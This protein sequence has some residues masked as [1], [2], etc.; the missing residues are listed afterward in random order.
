MKQIEFKNLDQ[1]PVL[2]LMSILNEPS[3]RLHL[4]E[5][6]QFD[7]T[8][9]K[10]WINE[11]LKI[12]SLI[13]CRIRA[14]YVGG[15]C[16]GWCGIQPDDRGYEIAIVISKIAWGKGGS[17]FKSLMKWAYEL[18]HKE[19]LFHLLDSRPEYKALTKIADRKTKAQL[20]DRTFTTYFFS[21]ID[22]FER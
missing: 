13:G 3:L 14:V 17:I 15:V 16:A 22:F 7:E 1:V 12:D 18:G 21:V 4:I 10:L 19:I 6:P 2:S 9:I 5:H 11:K 8:S 20:F